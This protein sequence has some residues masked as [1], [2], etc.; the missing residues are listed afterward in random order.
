[1]ERCSNALDN[2]YTTRENVGLTALPSTGVLH[3]DIDPDADPFTAALI[4]GR[5]KSR[6]GAD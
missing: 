6:S 5:H 1:V 4:A 2:T 3:K